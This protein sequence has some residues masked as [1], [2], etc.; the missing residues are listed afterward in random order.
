MLSV[1]LCFSFTI[2]TY[3]TDEESV[4]L[5]EQN[6]VVITNLDELEEITNEEGIEIPDGYTLEK[7]EY[8][9]YLDIETTESN[10]QVDSNI[11]PRAGLIYSISNVK[12]VTPDFCYVN[13]Y[14]HDIYEGPAEISTTFSFSKAVK[15]S[16][17]VNVGS[18]TVKAAVG[19]DITD[20]YNVSKTFKTTVAKGK[21]LEI[22]AYPVYRRTTFDI[23]NRWTD[24]LVETGA[25][26]NKVVG[27]YIAQYTYSK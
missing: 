23:Y 25:H 14:E 4:I 18:S 3:A 26:T 10:T 7:V 19:Y 21:I 9:T 24:K 17:G 1:I 12:I 27:V 8:C 2:F 13:E 6:H 22:K 15:R 16:I 11:E 5:K 20:T